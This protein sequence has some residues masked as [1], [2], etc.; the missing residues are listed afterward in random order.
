MKRASGH[1]GRLLEAE[2]LE[3]R[4]GDVAEGATAA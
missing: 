1:F 2:Q 4:G 3:D